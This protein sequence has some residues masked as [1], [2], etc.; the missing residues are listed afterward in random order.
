MAVPSQTIRGPFHPMVRKSNE[1]VLRAL[2]RISSLEKKPLMGNTPVIAT[3]AT[4]NVAAVCLSPA[5]RRPPIRA[6]SCSPC[7]PWITAPLPRKRQ[8]LKNACVMRWAVPA[9]N[10]PTPTPTNM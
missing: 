6:K 4:K 9:A 1:R 7:R 2:A 8:A 10:A 3:V 5:R